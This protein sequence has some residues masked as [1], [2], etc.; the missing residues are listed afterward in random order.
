VETQLSLFSSNRKIYNPQ[1]QY[2]VCVGGEKDSGAKMMEKE[3]AL[4][5]GLLKKDSIYKERSVLLSDFVP[6][7]LPHREQEINIMASTLVEVLRDKKKR[8]SNILCFG[9]TG[10][11]KTAVA[12]YLCNQLS[13][14]GKKHNLSITP[15]Y[16]R[17]VP[18]EAALYAD[19]GNYI[20]PNQTIPDRGIPTE[21]IFE[22]MRKTIENK[23]TG[24]VLII[25]EID[26][27][28]EKYTDNFLYNLT[29]INTD[30]KQSSLCLIGITNDLKFG[31]HLDS[32]IKSSMH[33]DEIIFPPYNAA[34]LQDILIQRAELAFNKDAVDVPVIPLCAAL[35][36]QEYGDAR[37][38]F[39]LLRTAGDVAV[40]EENEK[41]REEHVRKAQNKI[42]YDKMS[43]AIRTLPA[44]SK[45]VLISVL[46]G[47][48][49][50][51]DALTTGEVY[52]I[53]KSIAEKT[54]MSPLTQR[55][56]ADLISELDMLGIINARLISYGRGG[57]T[58]EITT[59]VPVQNTK[60][61][62][63][64]DET[65]H[66]LRDYKPMRGRNARLL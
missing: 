31:E 58:R 43:E 34:Q 1:T 8:T 17:K 32:R 64:Q 19:I 53:Y 18:S 13:E 22:R 42:E 3:T 4:F 66:V 25:D 7:R 27:A 48:E 16:I 47:K 6:D 21:K 46:L 26:N 20:E 49:N 29:R 63:L 38:A 35:A 41:V 56:I 50:G 23:N 37:R 54:G 30:L 36:A 10:T 55:R 12:K 61:I 39:E 11:G 15:L 60:E 62:L 57:R 24:V 5:E 2:R 52:D 51:K 33:A 14:T 45:M 9:K 65:F 59:A 40:R 28:C 44:Q